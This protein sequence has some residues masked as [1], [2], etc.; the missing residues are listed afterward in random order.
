MGDFHNGY[1][2]HFKLNKDRTKLVWGDQHTDRMADTKKEL[3]KIIF[4]QGFG[5]ITDLQIGPDGYLYVPSSKRLEE[6][7]V[8]YCGINQSLVYPITLV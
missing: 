8:K 1:I 2:Y 7:I 3:N 6:R 5:G 4:A